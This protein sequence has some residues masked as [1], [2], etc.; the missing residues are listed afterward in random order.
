[1]KPLSGNS[2][3]AQAFG[4]VIQEHIAQL[5]GF[6]FA[7][8][9][10]VLCS[11]IPIKRRSI[12]M[13][14][15]MPTIVSSA[16]ALQRRM[17]NEPDSTK[18]QRLHALYWAASGQAHH[19]QTI[20]ALLGVPRHSV[21][22]WFAAYARGG[23]DKALSYQASLPPVH[24]RISDTALTALQGKLQ[25]PHGF[26][27][28]NQIRVW[29]AKEHQVT[30]SYSSVHALVRY[31]LHAQPKRPRPAQA[32]KRSSHAPVS[33]CLAYHPS[34][35]ARTPLVGQH[36]QGVRPRRNAAWLTP[37]RPASADRLW[38]PTCGD[39]DAPVRQFLSLW[40]RRT[41]HRG[42]LFSRTA[43]PQQPRVPTVVGRLRCCLPAFV[44]PAGAR[45]RRRAQSPS[46][47]LAVQRPAGL[48]AP[49]RVQ[50]S[51]R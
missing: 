2:S 14:K 21:A 20:A 47:A 15:A 46:R 7:I 18:R 49:P 42:T 34:P 27:G 17:Q 37:R 50:N 33:N 6:L 35:T 23:L 41:A 43:V 28:Y 38:G 48:S 25:A 32:K 30:F 29:L 3:D 39:R 19:R 10:S 13:S 11:A 5:Y 8:I 36:A 45:Q 16:D 24:R 44:E 22:A 9:P 4:H 51:I 12:G 40:R 31:T 26:A 1:M